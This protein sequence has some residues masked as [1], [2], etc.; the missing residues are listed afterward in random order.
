M[1]LEFFFVLK[2][3]IVCLSSLYVLP[4]I[5]TTFEDRD[6]RWELACDL[7]SLTRFIHQNKKKR[8]KKSQTTGILV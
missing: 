1:Y 5:I 3:G 2:F 4:G 6:V 8:N 7:Q